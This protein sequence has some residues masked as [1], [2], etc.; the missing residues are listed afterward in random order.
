MNKNIKRFI[1]TII[2]SILIIGVII[3][4]TSN[5]ETIIAL[6]NINKIYFLLGILFYLLMN[7]V[8]A[9]RTAILIKGTGSHIS[10]LESF[11]LVATLTFFN[12]ITPF[13]F[14]GQPFQI[15]I[16]H[17]KGVP[18]GH[19]TIVVITKLL[20]GAFAL[21]GIVL[22]ALLKHSYLLGN[23]NAMRYG[24][25]ITIILILLISVLFILGLYKTEPILKLVKKFINFLK[26]VHIIKEPRKYTRKIRQQLELA[27]NSFTTFL[28]KNFI[29]FLSGFLLSFLMI[30][31]NTLMI[32]YFLW[33]FNA[34]I[35]FIEGISISGILIFVVTF[36]PTPGAS[37]LGEGVFYLMFKN[38][39]PNHVIGIL[40]FLWKFFTHYLTSFFGLIVSIKYFSELLNNSNE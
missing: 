31:F 9:L 40:I 38:Y 26:K 1:L 34:D 32:L 7:T 21:V 28:G 16:L 11:E 24:I 2:V 6:K 18:V 37:G 15:Y 33:G 27:K 39:T 14:G 5:K 25:D 17:K 13:S 29:Y 3:Y 10:I 36:L 22:Y 23:S 12:L 35:S 20:F 4:L 19:S 8:D 30:L